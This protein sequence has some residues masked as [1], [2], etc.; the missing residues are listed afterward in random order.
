LIESYLLEKLNLPLTSTFSKSN[1]QNSQLFSLMTKQKYLATLISASF[2]LEKF[3][4]IL[5][6]L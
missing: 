1:S 5:Q 3:S 2:L 6:A 4:H